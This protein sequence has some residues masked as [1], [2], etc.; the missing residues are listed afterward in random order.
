LSGSECKRFSIDSAASVYEEASADVD[1]N[2]A[3]P[4]SN[5]PSIAPSRDTDTDIARPNDLS[6]P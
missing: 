5:E 3:P 6:N 2:S 1:A 4:V